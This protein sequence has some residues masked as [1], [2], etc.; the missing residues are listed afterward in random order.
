MANDRH[1]SDGNGG[2]ERSQPTTLG[3]RRFLR[4]AGG[5]FGASVGVRAWPASGVTVRGRRQEAALAKFV[6]PLPVPPKAVPIG[7]I[8]GTPLFDINMVAFAQQLH[9]DLPPT[10]L[11]GYNGL[12]PGPTFEVQ[13]GKPIAVRWRNSLPAVHMF[14]VDPTLHGAQPPIPAVRT[15]VHVHGL[16]VLPDSDGYPEA[17]FT[18]SFTQRGPFFSRTIYQYPNDQNPTTLWYHDHALGITRLNVYAGLAGFYMIRDP[19]QEQALNLPSG[20]FEIPLLIQDRM[21]RP[22][23]VLVYPVQPPGDPEIPPVWVPE[24]FGNTVLVNGKV[25][26]FLEVQARKYRFRIVNG[27][28]A[29]FYQSTLVE[30]GP[31]GTP[32]GSPGLLFIQIGTD[33]GYLPGPVSLQTLTIAPAERMD[34]VIDFAGA[35]GKFF[36]MTNDANAPF[37]DGDDVIP[38]DVMLFKVVPRVG[39]D[40][41]TI[42]QH[43]PAAPPLNPATAVRVRDL[44]LTETESDDGNP[45]VGLINTH[46]EDPVTESPRAGSTEIWRII[47]TTED[48]HPIHVH[49]VQFQ[50]LDRQA[51]D[52]DQYPARLVFTGPRVPP[53]SNEFHA[54]KDTVQAFPGQVTRIISRF[55]LPRGTFVKPGTRLRYVYHCHILEHEDNDMMRPYDVVA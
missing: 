25:W 31:D 53:P 9:R 16:N 10:R 27:S 41:S 35:E 3:R 26:P 42:P 54:A 40:T 49:L 1:G 20:P 5:A 29:R 52:P 50:I 36:L 32:N 8:G 11:W 33:G 24:F 48:A 22:G 47:N 46:W 43:L 23:G 34:I 13:T 17:W 14:P 18:N 4:L 7:N 15:V 37:P 12:Y 51:F 19:I 21:F 45:V 55:D 2:T 28:N 44:V 6:D 38:G 39:P 30:A